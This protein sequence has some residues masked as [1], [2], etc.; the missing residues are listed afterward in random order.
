MSQSYRSSSFI[1]FNEGRVILD[2]ESFVD[3]A[4]RPW[5]LEQKIDFFECR[6]D[7]WQ[8]GVA[9]EM[10][11]QLEVH[12]PPSI[13]SHAAYGLLSVIASYFEMVG[14]V[15]NLRSEPSGTSGVDFNWGFCDVYP[16][17]RPAQATSP[18]WKENYPDEAVY[19][20]V[21]FRN[22]MRNGMYHL[23]FPKKNFLIHNSPQIS[24]DFDVV[25]IRDQ[26]DG[27]T[28][29]GV[30]YLMNPHRVTRSLVEHFAGIVAKLRQK[31]N[32][33]LRQKFEQFFDKFDE[34]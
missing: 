2:P 23:G 22:L 11:K 34:A 8:L 10:L 29:V 19:D 26:Q 4:S 14:K 18:G 28:S 3:Q 13:W 9:V 12:E 15:L 32:V 6:V 20:V 1:D 5:T 21:K 27:Q 16:D 33:D 25:D 30:V 31:S 17:F 7:V 24:K